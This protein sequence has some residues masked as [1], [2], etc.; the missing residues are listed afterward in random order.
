L[1]LDLLLRLV[2]QLDALSLIG[3][4]LALGDQLVQA[5]VAVAREVGTGLDRCAGKLRCEE[6]IP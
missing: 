1:L 5:L 4:G 6:V 3:N 2:V